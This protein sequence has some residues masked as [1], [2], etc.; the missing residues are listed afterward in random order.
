MVSG[1]PVV[2]N[3]TL[4]ADQDTWLLV[5]DPTWTNYSVE[6]QG[7]CG[8][9]YSS[10]SGST[11]TQI[12]TGLQSRVIADIVISANGNHIYAG[13]HEDGVYRLDLNGVP[14]E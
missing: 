9:Y 10:D 14:P 7:E 2:V 1:N 8:F 5:G 11:W 13:S 3:G 4:S 6:F 12:N